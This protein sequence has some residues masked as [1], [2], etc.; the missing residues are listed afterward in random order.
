MVLAGVP[1]LFEQTWIYIVPWCLPPSFES[2]GQA[3]LEEKILEV[4][5]TKP[6]PGAPGWGSAPI[7]TTYRKKSKVIVYRHTDRHTHTHT[8]RQPAIAIA[9]PELRSRWAKNSCIMRLG[10]LTWT[11]YSQI[12]C[13]T[14]TFLGHN[15]QVCIFFLKLTLT[16]KL[17]NWGTDVVNWYLP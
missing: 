10:L 3:V 6:H 2:I 4:F 14:N 16:L 13:I 7:L 15:L 8:H 12:W 9:D 17:T 11:T 1:S 5:G